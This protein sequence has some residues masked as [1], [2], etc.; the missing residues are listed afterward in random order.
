MTT[1][2]I[3][4]P[5]ENKNETIKTR[6]ADFKKYGFQNIKDH[7][8]KLYL[9]ASK[10][11]EKSDL[12]DGWPDGVEPIFVRTPYHHVAQRVFYYY[13]S[14]I[15]PD[16]ADWYIRLDEDSMTDIDGLAKILEARYDHLRDYHLAGHVH[17][18]PCDLDKNL[19]GLLGF[20]DWYRHGD[21]P[22]HEVE[23]SVT[24]NTAI[25]KFASN[26]LCKRYL[27]MRQE[28]AEGYGDQAFCH[29]LR[30]CKIYSLHTKFLIHDPDIYNF[31]VF[32]GFLNHIHHISRDN[33]PRM[34]EWFDVFTKETDES[35][36]NKVFFLGFE[37]EKKL[38]KFFADNCVCNFSGKRNETVGL[39]CVKDDKILMYSH[40]Q[41]D[42]IICLE[43]KGNEYLDGEFKLTLMNY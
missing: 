37:G 36:L 22:G 42:K 35:V 39:W 10:D 14:V 33:T 19:L 43:K 25:Q 16:R 38:V 31:S 15:E 20:A 29:A 41:K 1:F 32:G 21:N 28:F 5:I 17:Y 12:C 11:N 4:V 26:P 27:E 2:E 23:V 8:I 34:L 13:S 9:L 3:N 7:R 18:D 24:S 40:M 6:I 30:M